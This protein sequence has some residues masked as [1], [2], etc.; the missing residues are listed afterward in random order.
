MA[1]KKSK[2]SSVIHIEFNDGGP[3]KQ[4]DLSAIAAI[5]GDD[6]TDDGKIYLERMRNGK[7]RLLH[8]KDVISDF[9]AV[10][11]FTVIREDSGRRAI[12]IAFNDGSHKDLE[13]GKAITMDGKS[14]ITSGMIYL[15]Q[16]P[17][18]KWRLFY[19]KDVIEDFTTVK[20]FNIVRE[21]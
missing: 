17:D 6:G 10:N 12:E 2:V 11:T 4:L 21:G 5:G 18:G 13:I 1:K 9:D 7:W 19:T 3:V 16:L 14:D 20:S 15:D 8:T